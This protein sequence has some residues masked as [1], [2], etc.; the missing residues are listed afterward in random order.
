MHRYTNNIIFDETSNIFFNSTKII[1]VG[2]SDYRWWWR[3]L[4]TS[5][6]TALYVFLYSI[7]THAH[8]HTFIQICIHTNTHTHPHIYTHHTHIYMYMYTLLVP[9]QSFSY[10]FF[11]LPTYL[12]P[13]LLYIFH[14]S[15][16]LSFLPSL[17]HHHSSHFLT[18]PS[19]SSPTSSLPHLISFSISF[20]AFHTITPLTFSSHPPTPTPR[21]PSPLLQHT[22]HV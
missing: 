7:G 17:L 3:S 2:T 18:P 21:S 5:G 13:L 6:S 4:L 9:Y 11:F 22:S 20:L 19:Y 1:F 14:S 16:L 15:P 12:S 8:T 10:L